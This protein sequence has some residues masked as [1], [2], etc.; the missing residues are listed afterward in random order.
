[1]CLDF[2]ALNKLTIEDKFLIPFIHDLLA[3]LTG[4][5]YFTK[6]DLHSSYCQI[7]MKEE[8][9]PK[10]IFH[11]HKGHYEFLAMPFGFCNSP[12]TFQILMSNVFN[13]LFHHF[14]LAFFDDIIIH[15][16]MWQAHF[17]HV[18]QVLH[19][20]SKHKLFLKQSKCVFGVFEV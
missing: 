8:D 16:K 3:E 7:R 15:I 14:V 12:S 10:T 1:M 20:L 4:A 19:L 17:T 2:H 5:Q 6:I 18:D 11:M 13:P 9:I